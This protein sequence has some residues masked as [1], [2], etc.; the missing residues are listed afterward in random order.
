MARSDRYRLARL[1]KLDAAMVEAQRALA[2]AR[3]GVARIVL[4]YSKAVKQVQRAG[5]SYDRFK[6]SDDDYA[7]EDQWLTGVEASGLADDMAEALEQRVS[8]WS[9]AR[10]PVQMAIIKVRRRKGAERAR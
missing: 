3:S 5:K 6:R 1:R 10:E 8:A 9:E 4:R 7:W 2:S